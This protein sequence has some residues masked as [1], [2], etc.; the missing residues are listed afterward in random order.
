[1]TKCA[2]IGCR[3]SVPESRKLYCSPEHA[4]LARSRRYEA[5]H[6]SVPAQR[7]CAHRACSV[8][9]TP[10]RTDARFCSTHCKNAEA[11]A[12]R[13]DGATQ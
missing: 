10:K 3:K 4:K 6:K 11:W 2:L 12:R 7:E 13:Q 1:M 5:A 8:R 9:F